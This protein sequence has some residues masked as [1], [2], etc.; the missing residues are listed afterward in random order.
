MFF[1]HFPPFSEPSYHFNGI[2]HKLITN[3]KIVN[4]ETE[5]INITLNLDERTNKTIIDLMGQVMDSIFHK[6]PQTKW[7]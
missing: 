4:S 7:L 5:F 2:Q 3:D 1:Q 6:L